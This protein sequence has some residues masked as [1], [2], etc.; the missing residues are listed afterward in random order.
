MKKVLIIFGSV[1]DS[2]VYE[3]ITKYLKENG[4]GYDMRICSAH[5]TPDM[6]DEI[7]AGSHK[8][9]SLVV[10]GAG[11]A[12]HLPGVI[13]SKTTL[14]VIGI[15]CSGS[16]EGLDSFLSILQM[17]AGYPVLTTGIAGIPSE[18]IKL[19]MNSRMKGINIIEKDFSD[20]HENRRVL[21]CEKLIQE[22]GMDYVF[23]KDVQPGR[24][25]INF[26][27][28]EQGPGHDI[29]KQKAL[30]INVPLKEKTDMSDGIRIAKSAGDCLL[31]GINRGENA[32]IACAQILNS[33]CGLDRALD[34]L[35]KDM[36]DKVINDDR[37]VR[38]TKTA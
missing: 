24:I 20:E 27:R 1:S 9:Y 36:K 14:P 38:D 10:A 32:A 30:V 15:P 6:L 12:A 19:I 13:A 26:Y 7:L 17:P 23:K 3:R 21:D 18:S 28:L 34:R 4:I 25:N 31:L 11:L 35:R 8:R 33:S 37:Q 5:R 2:A 29:C 16:L 22:I